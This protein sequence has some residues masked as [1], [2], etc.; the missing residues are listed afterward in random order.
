LPKKKLREKREEAALAASDLNFP[1]NFFWQGL[2][3]AENNEMSVALAT[4]L[5]PK[6][7]TQQ[8]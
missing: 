8:K 5:N 2:H 7:L 1:L 4:K 6:K 3:R